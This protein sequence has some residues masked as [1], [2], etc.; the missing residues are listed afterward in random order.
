VVS[1][2]HRPLYSRGKSPYYPLYRR[3][4][5]PQ[6]RSGRGG[7]D[8]NSQPSSGIEPQN[9]IR[10]TRSPALYRLSHQGSECS[11]LNVIRTLSSLVIFSP[12]KQKTTPCPKE[13]SSYVNSEERKW[14]SKVAPPQ[15]HPPPKKK[16]RKEKNLVLYCG[17]S[18]G[19][20]NLNREGV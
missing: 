4:G 5:G 10:P 14:L 13:I 8:N 7:E 6:S 16:K 15:P 19:A 9:P 11:L 20:I 2:T 18:L 1:F 3:L 12:P 17:V